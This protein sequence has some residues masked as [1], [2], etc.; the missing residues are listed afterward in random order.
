MTT[1]NVISKVR[2]AIASAFSAPAFAPV[3][4]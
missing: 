4:A 1:A 2:D 3:L